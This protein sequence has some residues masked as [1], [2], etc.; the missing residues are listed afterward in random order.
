M[1]LTEKQRET[2]LFSQQGEMDAMLMYQKLAK[3]VKDQKDADTFVQL[4][5]EEGGHASVFHELTGEVLKPKKTKSIVVPLMYKICGKKFTYNIIAKNE[6][7][8]AKK[9][10]PVV[11]DFPQVESVK[12]DEVRHGDTVKALI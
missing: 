4:A 8:A 2:C 5:A 6:Y 7:D 3:V 12:N 11:K 10:E 9:Y 1:A